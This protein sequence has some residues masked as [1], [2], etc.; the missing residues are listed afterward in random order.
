MAPGVG[1]EL[2]FF[3]FRC[4][5]ALSKPVTKEQLQTLE[6]IKDLKVKQKTPSECGDKPVRGSCINEPCAVRVFHRR[7]PMV[8]DK[9]VHEMKTEWINDRYF[10]LHLTTSAGECSTLPSGIITQWLIF[11][12]IGT[13]V[14]EFVHGDLGRTL[15]NVGELLVGD[16]AFMADV[17]CPTRVPW[18][19]PTGLR[20]RYST[21]GRHWFSV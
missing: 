5:V 3:F 19:H 11:V 10:L 8:R 14:K 12:I 15:P 6:A 13:Y 17:A 4:V 2:L 21:I 20:G 7:S 16:Y 1:F 18:L 9:M